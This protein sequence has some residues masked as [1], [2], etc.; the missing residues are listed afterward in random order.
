MRSNFRVFNLSYII[1]H[2]DLIHNRQGVDLLDY[3]SITFLA[4]IP[5]TF[6]I[7]YGVYT[8]TIIPVL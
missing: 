4:L 7:S 1:M 3:Y 2:C 6:L 8:L 5:S